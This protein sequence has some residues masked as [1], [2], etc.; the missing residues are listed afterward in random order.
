MRPLFVVLPLLAIACSTAPPSSKEGGSEVLLGA[1]SQPIIGGSF[2]TTHQ[3]VVYLVSNPDSQ[4][5]SAA[6]TGTII[7][8]DAAKKVGWVL[9]AAHCVNPKP[10]VAIIADDV[11]AKTAVQFIVLDATANPAYTG[12]TTPTSHDVAMVRILGVDASTP[13]IALSSVTNDAAVGTS[14]TSVGYGRTTPSS[15]PPDNNS[16]RKRI[17][18]TLNGVSASAV[19]YSLSGGG[20]C[21]GDSGGPVLVGSGASERVLAVHSYVS[22]DCLGD[23]TSIRVS[24]EMAFINSEL[25]KALPSSLNSCATCNSAADSGNQVCAQ[26]RFACGADTDCSALLDCLSKCSGI[27]CQNNCRTKYPAGL[28][29][30]TAYQNC[31]CAEGCKAE[32]ASDN[33][34]AGAAQCGIKALDACGKCGEGSCCTERAAASFDKVGFACVTA[35]DGEGCAA[36]A[37]FQAYQACLQKSCSAE[38]GLTPSSSG[39]ASS[40]GASSG[41]NG[42]GT[43]TTTTT[44]CSTSGGS[45]SAIPVLGGLFALGLL[46]KRRRRHA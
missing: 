5:L 44:G 11:A 21:Q 12:Q 8:T 25:S 42:D 45:A 27:S 33:S 26:R 2:D 17:T 32:C 15:Q 28:G 9:T 22:G 16:R 23:G 10:A 29:P 3:A 40:G 6:C 43:T 4:G 31:G 38:C 36:N 14:V 41:G 34:C 20:I 18:R 24:G 39:G 30:F 19:S 13:T 7:K 1:N 37:P 35:P 46:L